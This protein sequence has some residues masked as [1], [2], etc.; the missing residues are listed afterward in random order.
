M[1]DFALWGEAISQAMGN[2]PLEFINAYYEN[3]GRQNIEAIES[4]SLGHAIARYFQEDDSQKE[5]NKLK[6]SPME[7]LEVLEG[8]AEQHRINTNHKLWPKS[9]NVLSR[10]LNQ[11]RSNL[12]EG[13]GIEVAIGRITTNKNGTKVNTSYIN[14]RKISP[15]CPISPA[16]QNHEGNLQ[17]ATGDISECWRYYISSG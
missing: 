2:K 3:I 1:A 11:I 7:V 9:P 17:K 12:L 16:G 13:L 5:L 10:R 14:M 8:F 4:H 15:V 6:G